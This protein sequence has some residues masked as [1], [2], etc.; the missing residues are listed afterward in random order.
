MVSVIFPFTLYHFV[1]AKLESSG[2][3]VNTLNMEDDEALKND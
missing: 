3:K 2:I 1:L